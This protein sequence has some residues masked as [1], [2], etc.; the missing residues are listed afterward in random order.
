[1]ELYRRG[2]AWEF[3]AIRQ[4]YDSGLAG[5]ATDFGVDIEDD[6]E[7]AG[8]RSLAALVAAP[9]SEEL[10]SYPPR[11]GGRTA[12]SSGSRRRE[13]ARPARRRRCC[14]RSEEADDVPRTAREGHSPQAG[15]EVPGG[16]PAGRAA[17]THSP[18]RS[19]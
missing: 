13:R 9:R 10:S 14:H 19:T 6:S 7:E 2:E 17:R 8:E 15:R 1:M 5:L 18:D 4:G 16:G 11:P 3:R 12:P